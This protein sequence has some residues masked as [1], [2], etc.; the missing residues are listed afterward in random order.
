M[1]TTC[2]KLHEDISGNSV[3]IDFNSLLG[4]AHTAVGYAKREVERDFSQI[5]N[6]LF[7]R[8]YNLECTIENLQRDTKYL[9]E[10]LSTMTKLEALNQP[11]NKREVLYIFGLNQDVEKITSTYQPKED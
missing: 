9:C 3:T 6:N 10:A 5:T 8:N 2:I 7:E 1:K 4:I 11:G